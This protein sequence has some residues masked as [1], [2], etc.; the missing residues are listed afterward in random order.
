MGVLDLLMYT[1]AAIL[2]FRDIRIDKRLGIGR[3]NNW[4]RGI[5]F[6]VWSYRVVDQVVPDH[7]IFLSRE[8]TP[9]EKVL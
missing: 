8:T 3:G 7:D 2:S 5:H 6:P 1:T 9:I 4:R